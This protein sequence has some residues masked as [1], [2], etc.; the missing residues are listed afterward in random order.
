MRMTVAERVRFALAVLLP[1][2][3]VALPGAPGGGALLSA[4]GAV[5]AALVVLAL[6]ARVVVGIAPA[7]VRAVSLRERAKSVGGVRFRDPDAR[8]RSRPRAPTRRFATA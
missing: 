1:A 4:A 8:G 5:A 6:V 3:F 2:L 7:G